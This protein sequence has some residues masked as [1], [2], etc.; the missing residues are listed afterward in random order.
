LLDVGVFEKPY[1]KVVGEKMSTSTCKIG[2]GRTLRKE[3]AL[4]RYNKAVEKY[5]LMLGY[6]KK[7]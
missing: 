1:S 4:K 5:C 7:S 6:A 2:L 3:L